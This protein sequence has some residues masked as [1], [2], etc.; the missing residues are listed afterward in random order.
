MN[1]LDFDLEIRPGDGGEYPVI[2]LRSPAGEA[3]TIM[4]FPFDEIKLHLHLVKLEN[5]LLRSATTHRFTPTQEEQEV[6]QFGSALFEALFTGEIRNRFEVSLERAQVQDKGLRIKLR[7]SAPD[8][9]ALPWEFL[10]DPRREEYLCFS[11]QTPIVRYATLPLPVKPLKIEPPLRIL[12]MVSSPRNLPQLEVTVEKERLEQPLRKLHLAGL[13][14]LHWLEGQTWR[15]LQREMRRGPWHVFHF[16]GHGGFDASRQEGFLAFCDERGERLDFRATHLARLLADHKAMRLVVLNACEG[17]RSSQQDVFSSTASILL[18][19]GIPAVLAMQYM[20]TDQAA[21]EFARTFYEAL[22]DG[23]AVDSAVA[24][25]RVAISLAFAD[26]IEWGTPVL[27]LRAEDGILF[28]VRKPPQAAPTPGEGKAT[29]SP[30]QAEVSNEQEAV[31]RRLYEDGLSAFYLRNWDKARSALLEVVRQKPDHT[32][33]VEKLRLVEE[34]VEFARLYEQANKYF[35]DENWQAAQQAYEELEKRMPSYKDVPSKQAYV[36]ARIRLAEL[37]A[38]AQRLSQ[39]GRYQAVLEIFDEI[40]ALDTRFSD[41]DQLLAAAQKALE[42]EERQNTLNRL[43]TQALRAVGATKWEEARNYLEKIESLQPEYRDTT[44][45]LAQVRGNLIS[46]TGLKS[47]T[48]EIAARFHLP[49][50]FWLAGA[51]TGIIV[52]LILAAVI[53]SITGLFQSLFAQQEPTPDASSFTV[54]PLRVRYYETDGME[55]VFVPEGEF[56]MGCDVENNSSYDCEPDELPL[57]TVYLDGFW[58]DK[59]EIT[60]AMYMKCVDAGACPRPA[61]SNSAT[62]DSYYNNPEFSNYPVINVSWVNATAYCAWAGRRL[63]SEAEWEKAARGVKDTLTYPWGEQAPDCALVNYQDCV[64][65]TEQVGA[66]PQGASPYGALDMAGNVWE[67]VNDWYGGFYY[68]TESSQ[69]NPSGPDGGSTKVLRGG[70]WAEDPSTLRLANRFNLSRTNG[71]FNV[72]FRC[73][74]S[75]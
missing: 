64:S 8:L 63:P 40:K 9:T 1:Y 49:K 58:I 32:E 11:R 38:D 67:W 62:Y 31:L 54:L 24:E 13:V 18:R 30:D 59:T 52:I 45:L 6:L 34:Q 26:T 47:K 48:A 20:I 71:G 42:E 74:D 10:Y 70:S 73:A 4:K 66:S 15:D 33:A 68:H 69:T 28:D 39:V 53:G 41:P 50:R 56:Q 60:N 25:G 36:R 55:T 37:Y 2:V 22:A 46:E 44:G 35:L 29:K 57:H 21:V 23:M 7:V 3:S 27:F 14:E 12:G 5:A 61:H 65:D 72:G 75:P 17:A 43:Y 51:A 19:G 16:I